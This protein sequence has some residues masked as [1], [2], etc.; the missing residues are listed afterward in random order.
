MGRIDDKRRG[1]G[2]ATF[3]FA[4]TSASHSIRAFSKVV[5]FFASV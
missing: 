5:C 1:A 2:A 3:A 4:L